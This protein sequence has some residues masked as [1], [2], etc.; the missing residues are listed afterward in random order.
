LKILLN[1]IIILGVIALTPNA[2]SNLSDDLGVQLS[3]SC[4]TMIKNGLQTNCPTYEEIMLFFLDTSDQRV[5][6]GFVFEDGYYHRDKSNYKESF[7]YYRYDNQSRFWV[8]PPANTQAKIKLIVIEPSSFE[9]KIQGQVVNSTSIEVGH[10][11]WLNV[12][13]SQARLSAVDWQVL[14]G[15]TIYY[16]THNCSADFTN[17]DEI[18]TKTWEKVIHDITTTYKHFFDQWIKDSL[19]RCGQRVCFYEEKAS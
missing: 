9:Y 18:K 6:G 1:V 17:F 15:D 13:C 2:Y 19:E 4:I 16:M 12:N 7:E 5:S 8:D 14:L 11:R 10:Q 3:K